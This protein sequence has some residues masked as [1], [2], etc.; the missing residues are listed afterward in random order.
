MA[1]ESQEQRPGTDANEVRRI[2]WREVFAFPHIFKSFRLSRHMTK[3]VIALAAVILTWG[4]GQVLDLAFTP[5][6]DIYLNSENRQSEPD[7]YWCVPDVGLWQEAMCKRIEDKRVDLAKTTLTSKDRPYDG[8]S[9]AAEKAARNEPGRVD[10]QLLA[11]Y[12]KLRE[13]GH[14]TADDVYTKAKAEADKVEDKA[15]KAKKLADAEKNRDDA[16]R[17]AWGNLESAHQMIGR[18]QKQGPFDT[19]VTY[20][21]HYFTQAVS[22]ALHGNILTGFNTIRAGRAQPTEAVPPFQGRLQANQGP[23]PLGLLAALAMM[24]Y[25]ILWLAST[26]WIYA[27]IFFPLLL[28]IWSVAGGAI[29]RAAALQAT[30]DEKAGVVECVKFGIKKVFSFVASPLVPVLVFLLIGLGTAVVVGLAGTIPGFG[31]IW[32]GLMFGLALIGGLLMAFLLIGLLAGGLLMTP[33][34]AVEGSDTFDACTRSYQFVLARPW[35]A[36]FYGLLAAVYGSLCYLFVRFLLFMTLLSAHWAVGIFAGIAGRG[37]VREGATKWDL[38]LPSPTFDDFN[39]DMSVVGLNFGDRFGGWLVH[40][41]VMLIVAVLIAWVVSYIISAST[42]VY[43]LLRK[44]EDATDLSEV[45]IE[46]PAEEPATP[47]AP[48]EA[49]APASDAPPAT[50]PSDPPPTGEQ[51]KA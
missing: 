35:R 29:A 40:A 45:Y 3:L 34:I 22:A 30:R 23:D 5:F 16:Y 20:E 50:P 32:I 28:V 2:N 6:S 49:A 13:D 48:A 36:A 31:G 9:E 14:K 42:M 18:F 41:W 10:S 37:Q 17:T 25:G 21:S 44:A 43:L 19:F 51:P 46:E 39:A 33:T 8:K 38:I 4:V 24:G 27:I 12:E 7:A 47:A 11:V 1:D 26:H 15:D